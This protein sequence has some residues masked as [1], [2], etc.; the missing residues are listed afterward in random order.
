MLFVE[1]RSMHLSSVCMCCISLHT[2]EFYMHLYLCMY[3][4]IYIYIYIYIYICMYV[5][6][7]I[8]IYIYIY[9]CIL[10]FEIDSR[11]SC[12]QITCVVCFFSCVIWSSSTH[13][14]KRHAHMC[15]SL[16]TYMCTHVLSI[17]VYMYTHVCTF[18]CTSV[19]TY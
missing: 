5:C 14:K 2:C 4:C 3:A 17:L 15:V 12:R 9:I 7:Y 13:E 19:P 1:T 8:Y 16:L 11:H 6:L 18:S 10:C